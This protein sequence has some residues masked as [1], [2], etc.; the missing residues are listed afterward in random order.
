MTTSPE[1]IACPHC[2]AQNYAVSPV[3]HACGNALQASV[4]GAPRFLSSGAAPA[5]TA[6]AMMQGQEYRKQAR[7]ATGSLLAVA[8][9]NLIGAVALY[10]LMTNARGRIDKDLM[11]WMIGGCGVFAALFFGLYFWAR[12]APYLPSLIGLIIYSLAT[13]ALMGLNAANNQFSIPWLN[14]VIIVL[15]AKG[16]TAAKKYEELRRQFGIQ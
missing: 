4:G 2:G 8:I 12:T 6:G 5:S 11:M 15:L 10:A 9:L 14:I 16:M 13:I 7:K 3:C 1:L